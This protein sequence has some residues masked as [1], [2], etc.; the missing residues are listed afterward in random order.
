[1]IPLENIAQFDELILSS[2]PT[3]ALFKADWCVDCRYLDPFLPDVV[4]QYQ[5]RIQF[6]V[7]DRDEFPE[8]GERYRVLGIPSFVAFRK[9]QQTISLISKL[10]KTREEIEGFLDRVVQVS[11]ELAKINP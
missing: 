5:D 8:L 4:K 9:G 1:M 3:V 10:R 11:D 2:K 7:V 6:V